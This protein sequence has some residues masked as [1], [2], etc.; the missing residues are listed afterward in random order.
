MD[1]F[2]PLKW[3]ASSETEVKSDSIKVQTHPILLHPSSIVF[4][5][6]K[7]S[8]TASL[9]LRFAYFFVVS[10]HCHFKILL[11]FRNKPLADGEKW[12]QNDI[13]SGLLTLKLH[14]DTYSPASDLFE[15]KISAPRCQPIISK[16]LS[17]EYTPSPLLVQ[18]VSAFIHPLEVI[19]Y[20]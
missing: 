19:I 11:F 15:I 8:H 7:T 20:F 17:F 1:I 5:L 13:D 9:Y 4:E 3:Q 10:N 2:G 12:T 16:L 14:H 6:T 18:A